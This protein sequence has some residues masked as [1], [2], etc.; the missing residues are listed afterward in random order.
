MLQVYAAASGDLLAAV[1]VLE[2][3]QNAPFRSLKKWLQRH[4]GLPEFMCQLLELVV[5]EFCVRLF[6]ITSKRKDK[7]TRFFSLSSPKACAWHWL[8][9]RA[10]AG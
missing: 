10:I 3:D 9:S 6:V 5:S 1:P 7:S 4:H 2:L 8:Q